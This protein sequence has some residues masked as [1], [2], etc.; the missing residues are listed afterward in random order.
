[1]FVLECA[2]LAEINLNLMYRSRVNKYS[3]QIYGHE[4]KLLSKKGLVV[5]ISGNAHA[6][7]EK[8]PFLGESY[9]PEGEF[10]DPDFTH[11][12]LESV[13]GGTFGVV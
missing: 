3:P 12:L 13:N 7:K 8:F 4:L 5:T 1:M 9:R 10:V 6:A 2:N 11:I